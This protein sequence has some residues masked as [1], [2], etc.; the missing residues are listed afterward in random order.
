MM[1]DEPVARNK[2]PEETVQ[3]IL[4][5]ALKLFLEKGYEHTTVQDIVDHLGGLSKGAIYHHF[6]SKEDIFIAASD[7]LFSQDPTDHW[8]IIR[9]DASLTAME[10][11]RAMFLGAMG[12]PNEAAFRDFAA[13]QANTPRFLVA[14]LKR[15]VEVLGPG[16]IQPVLEQGIAEG[17]LE[18]S[19][20]KEMAQMIMLLTNIWMDT[21]VFPASD[22][23]Y[24]RKLFF[25]MELLEKYGVS[26]F[27]DEELTESINENIIQSYNQKLKEQ[28]T[29]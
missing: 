18:T 13:I 16:Y 20:P 14:R 25:L 4:D 5:A 27:F 7:Y 24:M 11:V 9:D 10:K 26:D 28:Q 1:G 12:D 8:A 19:F 15:S 23:A 21:S 17:R 22:A 29:E 6:K 3:K 2:Y